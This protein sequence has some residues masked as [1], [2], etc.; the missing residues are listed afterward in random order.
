MADEDESLTTAE[1]MREL[2]VRNKKMARL[3]KL[4]EQGQA[5]GLPW[6]PDPLDGRIKRVKRADMEALRCQ[7]A[8]K[9]A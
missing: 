7:S 4:G 6:T 3:L 1:V 2:G 5:G 8:K 9:A